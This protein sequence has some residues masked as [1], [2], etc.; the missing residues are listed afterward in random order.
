M[1]TLESNKKFYVSNILNDT[2][3]EVTTTVVSTDITD[4]TVGGSQ[5]TNEYEFEALS[6]G[7][8]LNCA[9][10]LTDNANKVPPA[11]N[12]VTPVQQQFSTSTVRLIPRVAL[13]GDKIR[14]NWRPDEFVGDLAT[15]TSSAY[16]YD[17]LPH[18]AF[19]RWSFPVYPIKGE[20]L[21]VTSVG[22]LKTYL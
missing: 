13:P 7:T 2:Q 9:T 3:F 21:K 19:G 22:N 4:Q 8:T 15:S 17:N 5:T 11:L 1:L 16:N 12:E 20:S 18:N 10:M 14:V 6:N